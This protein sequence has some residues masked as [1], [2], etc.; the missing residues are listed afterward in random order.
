MKNPLPVPNCVSGLV[1]T[2]SLAPAVPAGVVAVIEVALVKMTLVA[3]VPPTVTVAP[4]TNP[5]PVIT[6]T[7][8]PAVGPVTTSRDV[9]VGA[10]AT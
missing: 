2:T 7:V 9:T 3:G 5:V 4:V 1:T 8:A 10:A 6:I